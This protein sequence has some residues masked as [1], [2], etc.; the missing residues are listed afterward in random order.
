MG[1]NRRKHQSLISHYSD[2]SDDN[3]NDNEPITKPTTTSDDE[4]NPLTKAE[5]KKAK[6]QKK[7]QNNK[8]QSSDIN[9]I[10]NNNINNINNDINNNNINNN[11]NNIEEPKEFSKADIRRAKKQKKKQNKISQ[12][13]NDINTNDEEKQLKTDINIKKQNNQEPMPEL[14]P[15]LNK[16]QLRKMKKQQIEDIQ[17]QPKLMSTFKDNNCDE[18]NISFGSITIVA[19]NKI[20]F[21]DSELSIAYGHRY[22]LIGKNGIG[23]SSLLDQIASRKIPID[24][25]MD[26][27]YMEQDLPQTDIPVLETVLMSNEKRYKLLQESNELEKLLDDES[28]DDAELEKISDKYANVMDALTTMGA[29]KDES[30]VLKILLGLGFNKTQIENPMK[31]LSGGWRIRVAL[32]KALYLEPTLLLLDEPTNHLDINATIWLTDY[33]SKWKHSLIVVSHNQHFLN[34]ITTDILNVENQKLKRYKGN[35]IKFKSKQYQN[36]KEMQKKWDKLQKTISDYRKGEFRKDGKKC[37]FTKADEKKILKEAEKK[38]IIEPPKEYKVSIEFPNP[39]ELTRPILETHDV[40]FEYVPGK[41]II[42][43]VDMGIDMDTRMTIV[44][45]NGTGKTTIINLLTGVLNPTK[46]IINRHKS[47]KIGCYNQHFADTLPNDI[48][49]I[50][51]LINQDPEL[52]K[53]DAKKAGQL[54]HKYLGSLGLESYAHKLPISNLS[55]GQK[56]R[57]VL[58]TIQMQKPHLLFLDEPT[59]HLDIETVD[60]LIDAINNYKGGVIVISHDMELITK[61]NCQLWVC[62]DGTI[63]E[64]EGDYDDYYQK[65][66]N[67]LE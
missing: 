30:L 12:Q 28:V 34:E 67:D 20:L 17:E 54:M 13:L 27:Y 47:L 65:I 48:T 43:H 53:E 21:Q 15:K 1:K 46:G 55:G 44:G 10:N 58:A 57:V 61:T 23:K 64:F 41:P 8:I 7:K 60:A 25:K 26:V 59:N 50:Q 63:K 5:I 3:D 11:D 62:Q 2:D 51:H 52:Q 37:N 31:L 42:N 39:T 38:D 66:I 29:D 49:P 19:H 36:I 32:A 24:P 16:T 4:S 45:N 40:Y 22:G 18:K 14:E 9:N 6:K 35:Y 56:A 33:L